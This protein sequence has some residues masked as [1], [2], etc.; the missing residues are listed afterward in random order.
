MQKLFAKLDALG[1]GERP[2][3]RTSTRQ[4][5]SARTS[6]L[7]AGW[8]M[9]NTSADMEL[10]SSLHMLR[11]RSRQLAR[12]VG[13]AKRAKVL[14]V[15]NVIGSGIGLQA[16]VKN[17]RGELNRRVNSEIEEVFEYLGRS[18]FFHTGGRLSRVMFERQAMGQVF[19]A[20]EVFV[21]EHNKAFGGSPV[22]YALE[23]I[24]AERIADDM[25]L[26]PAALNGN[27]VR[28]GVEVDTFHR[29][30]AYYIRE[31]HPME[32]R[33]GGTVARYERVPA[34]QIIHLALIDRWP[35]TR[36]EPWLHAAA[37]S[38]DNMD[39]YSE[40]EIVR[41]RTQASSVGAIETPEESGAFSEE[42]DDGTF[43]LE[44]EPGI[45]KRLA[46]G[47]KLNALAPTSPNPQ[48]D[49][50]MR[51]MLREVASAISVSYASLSSDYSQSNYS[52]SRLALLDDR[53]LWK[54][55]QVWFIQEFRRRV[56]ANF[57]RQATLSGA[58]TSIPV[59][60]YAVDPR[61]FEA[62]RFKPRGWTWIDPTKEVAAFKEAVKAGFTTVA[63]VVANSNGGDD[64]ED[65]LEGR[66]QELDLME[67]AGLEF[68]T[69][70]E[71]YMAEA[72]ATAAPPKPAQ[73]A[74][75]DAE[76]GDETPTE[77]PPSRV[78]SFPRS[79]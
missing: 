18:E 59:V 45:Y 70:P 28:M 14:V 47:E 17:S 40:A 72:K 69:S 39:G 8:G 54:Y 7:T 24:E 1:R 26:P 77:D 48:M 43:V 16:Q 78:F 63:N 22:P 23:L 68:D 67:E 19:E 55:L 44:T 32:A 21:R 79:R 15:N 6:R 2:V 30:L 60:Q 71:F 53:D 9:S 10:A 37:R 57:L 46:P 5:A 20:G 4:Y 34:D 65:V 13:Y 66:R 35:Q 50:F 3:S 61:K 58:I 42:Q 64:M 51:Y 38:L 33:W 12:D 62:V 74:A 29:P 49:P 11:S 31:R 52:S 36:G 73:A 27:Q 41:A 75:A 76:D 25:T 56:H